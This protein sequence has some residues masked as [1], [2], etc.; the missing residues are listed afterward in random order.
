MKKY[1]IRISGTLDYFSVHMIIDAENEGLAWEQA[2]NRFHNF[3]SEA[4][5]NFQQTIEEVEA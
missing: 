2:E 3:L 5:G 4:D 1:S